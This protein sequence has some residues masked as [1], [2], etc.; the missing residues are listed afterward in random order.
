M[1]SGKSILAISLESI[2]KE[3]TSRV[4]EQAR[5]ENADLLA[6]QSAKANALC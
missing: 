4:E 5:S 2:R 6:L 1:G 3:S